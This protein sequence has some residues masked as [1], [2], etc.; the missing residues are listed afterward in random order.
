MDRSPYGNHARIARGTWV[1]VD[2][3]PAVD[4]DGDDDLLMIATDKS[5]RLPDAL[6]VAMWIRPAPDQPGGGAVRLL[7]HYNYL[8]FALGAVKAPY[9]LWVGLA[10][11]GKYVRARTPGAIPADRWTHVAFTFDTQHVVVYINGVERARAA[12]KGRL[13]FADWAHVHLGCH[14]AEHGWYHGQYGGLTVWK[15]ALSADAVQAHARR[16]VPQPGN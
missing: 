5:L 8:S 3:R 13:R 11:T 4:L 12:A 6:T 7:T 14:W 10:T 9:P 16:G 15:E 2:G 1:V